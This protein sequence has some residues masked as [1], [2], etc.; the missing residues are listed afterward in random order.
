MTLDDITTRMVRNF[1]LSHDWDE[2]KT[3][4]AAEI[5]QLAAIDAMSRDEYRS[6]NYDRVAVRMMSVTMTEAWTAR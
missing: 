2:D 4:D 1:A 5:G 6:W 3:R